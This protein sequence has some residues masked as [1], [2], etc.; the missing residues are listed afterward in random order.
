[1]RIGSGRRSRFG[2]HRPRWQRVRRWLRHWS[3]LGAQQCSFE[4][5]APSV[6]IVTTVLIA[7]TSPFRKFRA[8]RVI[9]PGWRLVGV[10]R[11]VICSRYDRQADLNCQVTLPGDGSA[12]A[13]PAGPVRWRQ[14]DGGGE[15]SS[16]VRRRNI[17]LGGHSR[18][19]P[20]YPELRPF[21]WRNHSSRPPKG[22]CASFPSV[23]ASQ[24]PRPAETRHRIRHSEEPQ[25]A[26]KNRKQPANSGENVVFP[27]F[28][29]ALPVAEAGLEPATPGL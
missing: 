11:Q 14:G 13:D 10:E 18:T 23:S 24:R 19:M 1:M 21:S 17:T 7:V 22:L 8:F 26:R 2:K 15:S 5:L 4:P 6:T 16:P 20:L 9:A 27:G 29:D 3:L 28:S 12:G 25:P